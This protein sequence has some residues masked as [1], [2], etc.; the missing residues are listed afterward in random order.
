MKLALYSLHFVFAVTVISALIGAI[1]FIGLRQEIFTASYW[2]FYESYSLIPRVFLSSFIYLAGMLASY[3]AI[4]DLKKL[5]E[6]EIEQFRFSALGGLGICGLALFLMVLVVAIEATVQ[7]YS[8]IADGPFAFEMSF[9][10]LSATLQYNLPYL[11]LGALCFYL[12]Y[13]IAA[14]R[15]LASVH[16]P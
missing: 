7:I 12:R 2:E 1:A 5:P 8:Y 13:R 3:A 15:R 4:V 14:N 10:I 9:F 11:L 16:K 6:T